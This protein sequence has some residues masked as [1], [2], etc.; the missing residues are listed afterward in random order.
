M[1]VQPSMTQFEPCSWSLLVRGKTLDM[2]MVTVRP[3]VEGP[4]KT[5]LLWETAHEDVWWRP[6]KKRKDG[7]ETAKLWMTCQSSYL[8]TKVLLVSECPLTPELFEHLSGSD[9]APAIPNFS[10]L[11]VSSVSYLLLRQ[12]CSLRALHTGSCWQR[13]LFLFYSTI[14]VLIF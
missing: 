2:A 5:A 6:G 4:G 13:R 12:S 11:S 7:V 1:R 3:R 9:L 14:F 10:A 8:A